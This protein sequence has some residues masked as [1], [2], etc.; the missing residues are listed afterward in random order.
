MDADTKTGI[1]ATIVLIAVV[2][3]LGFW[4]SLW[5]SSKDELFRSA[6]VVG[7]IA[8]PLIVWAGYKKFGKKGNEISPAIPLKKNQ[9]LIDRNQNTISKYL[10]Q[11]YL[12]TRSYYIENHVRDCIGEIARSEG[13]PKLVPA[14]R[15]WLSQWNAR[16]DIPAEY[17]QLADYLKNVFEERHAG[18]KKQEDERDAQRKQIHDAYVTSTGEQLLQRSQDLVD[19]FLEIAERKVSVLDSYGDEQW[20]VLPD[21]VLLCMKKIAQREGNR[22]DWEQY[23]KEKRKYQGSFL[24][25]RV[26]PEEYRWVELKLEMLFQEHHERAK[27]RPHDEVDVHTMSG[28]EFET[29]I[30]RLLRSSGYEVSGTQTTGDQGADLIAKKNGRTYIIQAKRYQGTVGNKAVQEAISALSYYGGHEAWV[31]T[32]STFTPSAIALAQKANIRLIDGITLR[33][34]AFL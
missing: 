22:I 9:S 14:Y 19:K 2:L 34:K 1:K 32:N 5:D 18:L 25:K 30:A 13:R 28:V 27:R 20:D 11:I 15:E 33:T 23:A 4:S 16:I 12:N 10:D 17:K 6:L 3:Y 7:F 29:H 31:I 24:S 8:V 26:L 21:E